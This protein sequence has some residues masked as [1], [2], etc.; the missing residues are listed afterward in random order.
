MK[1][2]RHHVNQKEFRYIREML[3][4]KIPHSWIA[5]AS[6]R[7]RATIA[8]IGKNEDFYS[9]KK[10]LSKLSNLSEK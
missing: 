10:V 7:N 1:K 9:Y 2:H 5:R 6:L 8:R 3:K 4:D